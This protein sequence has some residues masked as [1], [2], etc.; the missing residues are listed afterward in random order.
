MKRMRFHPTAALMLALTACGQ[1]T[2]VSEYERLQ[3]EAERD[4][5]Q[6]ARVTDADGPD[7]SIADSGAADDRTE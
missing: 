7:P 6:R 3:A 1:A 2:G 5:V 4:A